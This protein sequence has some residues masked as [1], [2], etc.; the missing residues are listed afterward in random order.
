MSNSGG[1][2][3]VTLDGKPIITENWPAATVGAPAPANLSFEFRLGYGDHTL[4][5]ENPSGP[6]W[7]DL[8]GLELGTQVPALIATAK[9]G[10]DRTA[11]W[12]RHRLNLLSPAEDEDL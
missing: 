11:L 10:R 4:V 12:V 3:T 7:I 5:L 6:D 9:H 2:L 8:A 1:S